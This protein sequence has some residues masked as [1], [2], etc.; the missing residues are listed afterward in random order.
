MYK[1]TIAQT[2][3]SRRTWLGRGNRG[4]ATTELRLNKY[5]YCTR[6]GPGLKRSVCA[7]RGDC[8]GAAT[9]SARQTSVAFAAGPR[10]LV[11]IRD[12]V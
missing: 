12:L 8:A 3:S 1:A 7:C 6:P 4:W 9:A 10:L 5:D 11:I 2:A